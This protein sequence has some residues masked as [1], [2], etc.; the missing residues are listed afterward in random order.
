MLPTRARVIGIVALFQRVLYQFKSGSKTCFLRLV[1]TPY[2]FFN[3]VHVHSA[4]RSCLY[5]FMSSNTSAGSKVAKLFQPCASRV[6][7]YLRCIAFAF[8]LFIV[9]VLVCHCL[10]RTSRC[11]LLPSSPNMSLTFCILGL[12][13]LPLHASTLTRPLRAKR[14]VLFCTAYMSYSHF[15]SVFSVAHCHLHQITI[16][17]RN[18]TSRIRLTSTGFL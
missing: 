3:C 11:A 7:R 8:S 5:F 12:V 15:L 18:E 16:G 9:L 2:P 14:F 6:S 17:V 13:G 4:I 1:I 10:K